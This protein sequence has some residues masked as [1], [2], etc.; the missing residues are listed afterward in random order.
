MRNCKSPT[1]PLSFQNL[2]ELSHFN[3]DKETKDPFIELANLLAINTS[4]YNLKIYINSLQ[5]LK[6]KID[7]FSKDLSIYINSNSKIKIEKFIEEICFGIEKIYG[8]VS[9]FNF[10]RELDQNCSINEI[11]SNIESI[12]YDISK[13]MDIYKILPDQ[14]LTN[15][16]LFFEF[17][18]EWYNRILNVNK[19]Y[20]MNVIKNDNMNNKVLN[21]NIHF[22]SRFCIFISKCFK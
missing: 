9:E 7:K 6:G 17:E 11:Y 19:I 12:F 1:S 2:Y 16:K 3:Y 8:L 10:Y 18:F 22:C 4:V 13:L 20:H 5:I 21:K 15:S 14:I